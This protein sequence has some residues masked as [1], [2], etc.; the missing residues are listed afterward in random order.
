[1]E[2][3]K[4]KPDDIAVGQ[5][6]PWPMYD[7]E[8]RLL[9]EK[10]TVIANQGQLESLLTRGLYRRK[11]DAA[12]TASLDQPM[13]QFEDESSPFFDLDKIIHQLPKL[14]KSVI[15][16][17]RGVEE[18]I[19]RVCTKLHGLCQGEPDAM[20]GAVHVINQYKYTEYHPVHVGILVSVFGVRMG[21]SEDDI[22]PIIAAALTANISMIEM[23]EILYKQKSEL[24]PS[25]R[26]EIKDHPSNTVKMLVKAGIYNAKW[27]EVIMQHHE[28]PDGSGY[29]NDLK[30]GSIS[31]G[32]QLISIADRYSSMV[33]AREYRE[34][35]SSSEALKEFFISKNDHCNEEMTLLFIKELGI[36]P[37][38][39]VVK[40]VNGETAIVIK[41]SN[42][43]MWPVVSSVCGAKGTV[44]AHPLRRDCNYEEYRIKSISKLN[45]KMK[46]NFS[47]V[48]DFC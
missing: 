25:Q 17:Q 47:M 1:M 36:W 41:R 21:L 27:L 48:W 22:L 37:P 20:L 26:Q 6:L 12:N 3:L 45:K 19:L 15:A 8:N 31:I 24:T 33:S 9:L 28:R 13:E 16:G 43:S 10:G 44:Y 35:K 11:G 7:S 32:A 5:G 4:V 34:A 46:L 38:G 42:G 18:T 14:F 29:P 2:S 30:G 40:L 23:Q 39:T